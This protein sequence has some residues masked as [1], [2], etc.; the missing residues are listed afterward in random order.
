VIVHKLIAH[1]SEKKIIINQ[2]SGFRTH[3][4]TKDNIFYIIQKIIESFNRKKSVCANFFDIAAAFDK[5]WHNGILFK[6]IQSGFP[7]FLLAWINNFLE[8][9]TGDV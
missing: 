1:L 8:S 7:H 9:R 2:Q 6:L 3:R 4:Q 5:V